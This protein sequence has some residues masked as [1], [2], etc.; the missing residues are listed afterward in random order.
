M[1]QIKERKNK[2]RNTD[3]KMKA[4]LRGRGF[5]FNSRTY[6]KSMNL[7]TKIIRHSE[8]NCTTFIE[9]LKNL[10]MKSGRRRI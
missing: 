3:K 7:T 2:Y 5:H 6:L 9:R 1:L 4:A 8:K 10:V